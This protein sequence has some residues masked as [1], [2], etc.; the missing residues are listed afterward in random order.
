MCNFLITEQN[1]GPLAAEF[2]PG[3]HCYFS[4]YLAKRASSHSD[5]C[6]NVQFPDYGTEL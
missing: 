2:V 3:K 1:S 4:T 6:A 5:A